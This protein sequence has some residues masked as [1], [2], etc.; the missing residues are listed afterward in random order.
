MGGG[1]PPFLTIF[2]LLFFQE[3]RDTIQEFPEQCTLTGF[4]FVMQPS[5]HSTRF[6]AMRE[7]VQYA[8][9]QDFL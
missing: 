8:G 7:A 2:I 4:A 5:L 3:T 9:L 6:D 1:C